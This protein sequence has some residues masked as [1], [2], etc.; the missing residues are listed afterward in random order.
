M[1]LP[2]YIPVL[3][4]I[5]THDAE[6][7]RHSHSVPDTSVVLGCTEPLMACGAS[8]IHAIAALVLEDRYAQTEGSGLSKDWARFF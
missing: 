6:D 3:C 1:A 5:S 2:L 8:K 7:D 4:K